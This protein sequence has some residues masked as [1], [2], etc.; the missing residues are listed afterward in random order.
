MTAP[1]LT[2]IIPSINGPFCNS[3]LQAHPI[4]LPKHKYVV[5]RR[6]GDFMD[7]NSISTQAS[8]LKKSLKN[9]TWESAIIFN[10]KISD[11]HLSVAGYNS[12]FQNENR[13]NEVLLWFD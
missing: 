4:K 10:N 7:D 5:V 13:I 2:N 8:A 1:V 3:Q 9:S 6:F 12:P 11:D